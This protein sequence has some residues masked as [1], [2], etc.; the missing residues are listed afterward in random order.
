MKAAACVCVG[1]IVAE[2]LVLLLVH[3]SDDRCPGWIS[4]PG[5]SSAGSLWLVAGMFTVLPALWICYVALRWER[6]YARRMYDSIVDG[7]PGQLLLDANWLTLMVMA[8]WC[9]FCAM[10]LFLMLGRCTAMA[11]YFD[12]FHF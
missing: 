7:P 5:Q 10:P 1:L 4:H 6:Y 11:H 2:L 9:L 3:P 12:A 8:L